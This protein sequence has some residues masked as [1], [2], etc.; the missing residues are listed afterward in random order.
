MKKFLSALL[1]SGILGVSS[2]ATP[3]KVVADPVA[4]GSIDAV[5]C[6]INGG[7][8]I[9]GT[10]P[11]VTGGVEPTCPLTSITGPGKYTIVMTVVKNETLTNVPGTS[12]AYNP[13]GSASSSPFVY[14][15]LTGA[16]LSNPAGLKLK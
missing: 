9:A 16:I 6:T 15:W 8:A 1:L 11:T 12:G 4:A 7:A 10:L 5:S 13:G 3:T 14:D 2:A